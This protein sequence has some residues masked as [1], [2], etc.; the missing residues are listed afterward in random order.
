MP[1]TLYPKR[2]LRKMMQA[3]EYR[4]ALEFG[5]SLGEKYGEDHD[6]LFIMGSIHYVLENHKEAIEYFDSAVSIQYDDIEALML[7]TNSHLALGQSQEAM[8]CCMHILKVN[9]DHDNAA[10]LLENLRNL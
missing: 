4:E 3:G 2:R 9:P 6:F 5:R 1:R 8:T 7:K 10:S